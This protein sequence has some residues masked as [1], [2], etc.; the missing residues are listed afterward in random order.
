MNLDER[1]MGELWDSVG[2]NIEKNRPLKTKTYIKRTKDKPIKSNDKKNNKKSNDNDN[3]SEE[4]IPLY[5][6]NKS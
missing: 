3:E 5:D 1:K 6:S 2:D 4:H